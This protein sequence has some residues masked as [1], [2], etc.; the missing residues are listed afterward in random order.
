MIFS[1]ERY[2]SPGV[3]PSSENASSASR[4]KSASRSGSAYTATLPI[5]AS[6]QARMTRT[7]ISPRLAMR[8]FSN[9]FTSGTL[10]SLA[11]ADPREQRAPQG[12]DRHLRRTGACWSSGVHPAALAWSPDPFPGGSMSFRPLAAAAL[13]L[14][15]TAGVSLAST[16]SSAADPAESTFAVIGDVPYGAAQIAAFPSWIQQINADP[17]VSSV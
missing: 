9:G 7:A 8:T 3:E 12:W 11:S 15:G 17:D 10:G 14:A 13:A 6:L 1:I 2:E 16:P 5:P 4:T